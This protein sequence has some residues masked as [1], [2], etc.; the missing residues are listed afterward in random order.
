M[1][2]VLL[3]GPAHALSNHRYMRS[4]RIFVSRAEAVDVG[5]WLGI[6]GRIVYR[7]RVPLASSIGHDVL[8]E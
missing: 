3:V 1:K 8:S 2:M 5:C 4:A 6:E 7:V